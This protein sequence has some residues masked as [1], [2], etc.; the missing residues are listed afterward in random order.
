MCHLENVNSRKL[1]IKLG[2]IYKGDVWY[3]D[4]KRYESYFEMER[5]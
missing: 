4:T 3:D 5:L 1:L 2:F